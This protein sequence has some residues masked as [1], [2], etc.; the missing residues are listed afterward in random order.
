MRFPDLLQ[1]L[2]KVQESC[3]A[4][5]ASTP[6]DTPLHEVCGQ[7]SAGP[8]EPNKALWT[9]ACVARTLQHLLC[10]GQ[11]LA[12]V[13]WEQ[14]CYKLLYK[15]ERDQI[16]SPSLS[17]SCHRGVLCEG[18]GHW[19]SLLG[20]RHLPWQHRDSAGNQSQAVPGSW[21]GW[22]MKTAKQK[23]S[24][25]NMGSVGHLGQKAKPALGFQTSRSCLS[26]TVTGNQRSPSCCTSF[27]R[28]NCMAST[29]QDTPCPLEPPCPV[30]PLPDAH[31][32]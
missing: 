28:R 15:G 25:G 30:L 17:I 14:H 20:W 16:I 12:K 3:Y 31:S 7:L 11:A 26:L 29:G 18:G 27:T 1:K 10:Q 23:R 24:T 9:W 22:K 32:S 8:L 4:S 2:R 21:M 6:W 19:T 13:W 5:D